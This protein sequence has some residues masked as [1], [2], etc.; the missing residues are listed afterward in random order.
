M[1]EVK[2]VTEKVNGELKLH[3]VMVYFIHAPI[4]NEYIPNV[5]EPSFGIGRIMYSL[6]EHVWWVRDGDE[7]R[8]V[9]G[10]IT[11]CEY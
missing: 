6:M 9:I 1:V 8:H 5:I 7:N 11:M 3:C 2:E 10:T 4:V